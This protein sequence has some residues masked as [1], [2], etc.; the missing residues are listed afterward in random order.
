MKRTYIYICTNV[1]SDSVW[2]LREQRWTLK[3]GV[4]TCGWLVRRFI[5][6]A[7]TKS[8]NKIFEINEME[9]ETNAKMKM[10]KKK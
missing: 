10:K 1:V 5:S 8:K 7:V 6:C 2:V 4:N 3:N 9:K